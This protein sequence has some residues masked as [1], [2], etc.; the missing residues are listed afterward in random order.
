MQFNDDLENLRINN[1]VA[2]SVSCTS[3]S[4]KPT[5]PLESSEEESSSD[6]DDDDDDDEVDWS[7]FKYVVL[8][9]VLKKFKYSRFF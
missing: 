5:S 6:E 7:V 9:K 2:W 8:Q 4:K 1:V 3:K